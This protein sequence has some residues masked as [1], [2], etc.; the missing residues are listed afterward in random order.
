MSWLTNL[1]RPA[2]A[3]PR[4]PA[5]AA[6]VSVA[7]DDKEIVVRIAG[8][9]DERLAWTDLTRVAVRTTDEGPFTC[10]L[11]W[12]LERADGSALTV[13]MGSAGEAE[14]LA[15]LQHRL[16]GFDNLAVVE[17]M[18]STECARYVVWEP[19]F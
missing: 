15:T 2:T 19:G 4:P 1:F 7:Y 16:H 17:A 10:D 11:F 18:G 12:M 8:S 5:A 6:G 13:P 9:P 3:A 14:L